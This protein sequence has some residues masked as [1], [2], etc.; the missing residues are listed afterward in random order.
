MEEVKL[1]IKQ[2]I[3]EQSKL[4]SD[5]NRGRMIINRYALTPEEYESMI[6]W[7]TDWVGV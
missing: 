6:A 5:Y 2:V 7:L 4:W 3:K 1:A